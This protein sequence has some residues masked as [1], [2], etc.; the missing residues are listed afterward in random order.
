VAFAYIQLRVFRPGEMVIMRSRTRLYRRNPENGWLLYG[1]TQ[2]LRKEKTKDD[3][4][5]AEKSF[6][7]AWA[8]A[9]VKLT[10][11]RF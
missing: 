1:L 11:S 5:K 7:K 4:R 8:K 6:R 3:A 10:A 2:N 9:D